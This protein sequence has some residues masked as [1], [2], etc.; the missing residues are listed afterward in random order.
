MHFIREELYPGIHL[1][2][3]PDSRFKTN[4]LSLAFLCD[5]TSENAA[6]AHLLPMVLGRGSQHYPDLGA[7][8]RALEQIWD[9]TLDSGTGRMGETRLI[10]F[11]A[12]YPDRHFLPDSDP[13]EDQT[14]D[15][16]FDILLNPVTTGAPF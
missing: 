16:F 11:S 13:V 2:V 3:L 15:I 6:P 1:N 8:N 14:L 9:G 10:G 7:I 5:M 4:Y 12:C